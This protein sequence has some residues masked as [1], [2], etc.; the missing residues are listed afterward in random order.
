MC[1]I[2]GYAGKRRAA[3]ILLEMLR[4]QQAFD[5]DMSTGIATVHEGKL[6]CRKIVGDVDKLIAETDVLDLPGT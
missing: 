6:Y 4:R 2:A 1:N 5:G 3:P